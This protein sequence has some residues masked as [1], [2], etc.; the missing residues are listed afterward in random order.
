MSATFLSSAS[1]CVCPRPAVRFAPSRCVQ[2]RAGADDEASAPTPAP[3]APVTPPAEAPKPSTSAS[4]TLDQQIY[5]TL[6]PRV[7]E[8]RGKQLS[9][10]LTNPLGTYFLPALLCI[11]CTVIFVLSRTLCYR[12]APLVRR[13]SL[14]S[15]SRAR[16]NRDI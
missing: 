9:K 6:A 2:A 14:V 3:A 10:G 15:T 16:W 13:C 8:L 11:L 12:R 4:L 1:V 7:S 5:R